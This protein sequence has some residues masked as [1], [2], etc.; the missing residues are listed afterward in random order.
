MHRFHALRT[1]S[2]HIFF[3]LEEGPRNP[4]RWAFPPL[5]PRVVPRAEKKRNICTVRSTRVCSWA[6]AAA[7]C[8][9]LRLLFYIPSAQSAKHEVRRDTRQQSAPE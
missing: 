4:G 6:R 8:G 3:T 9:S 7:D 5:T 2:E 1:R